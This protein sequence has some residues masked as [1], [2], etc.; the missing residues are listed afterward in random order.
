MKTIINKKEFIS[1]MAEKGGVT[2]CSCSKYVDLM[3]STFYELLKEGITV[4]FC[5]IMTVEVF[6]TAAKNTYNIGTGE[7]H[8]LPSHNTVKVRISKIL[9]DKFNKD[10]KED[11]ELQE[12]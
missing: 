6:K 9:Q 8:T 4:Q 2:K 12:D 1:R 10:Y 5:R 11:E 7:R 3:L